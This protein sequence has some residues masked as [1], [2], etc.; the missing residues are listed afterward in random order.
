M[1]SPGNLPTFW[2]GVLKTN[3]DFMKSNAYRSGEMNVAKSL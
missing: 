1:L 2:K 3:F